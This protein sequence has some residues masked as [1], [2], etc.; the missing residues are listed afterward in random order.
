MD[1]PR[2]ITARPDVYELPEIGGVEPLSRGQLARDALGMSDVAGWVESS[3]GAIVAVGA[4]DSR[5]VLAALVRDAGS[6]HVSML[7]AY[8]AYLYSG[9]ASSCSA[10]TS[11]E[12][13]DGTVAL[14]VECVTGGSNH[15]GHVFILASPGGR[16]R[17]LAAF[18][19]GVTS[20]V[21]SSGRVVVSS[22]GANGDGRI[23][24]DPQPEFVL[25]WTPSEYPNGRLVPDDAAG[26]SRY[27]SGDLP[28][29]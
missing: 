4:R 3:P 18:T 26:W 10:S 22:I 2:A 11:T 23:A 16:P 13:V 15:T 9:G 5:P 25:R 29:E 28:F 27:C 19:C 6:W 12:V 8:P 24:G 20:A 7:Y 21:A 14:I 1:D 17:L